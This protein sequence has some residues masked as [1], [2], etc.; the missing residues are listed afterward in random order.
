MSKELQKRHEVEEKYTWD[1]TAIYETEEAYEKDLAELRAD[2]TEFIE[3][4]EDNLDDAKIIVQ[5]LEGMETI[6]TK[7][8]R[9]SQYTSLPTTVDVTDNEAMQLSRKNNQVLAELSSELSFF[10]VELTTVS[11][12]VLDQVAHLEP[13][14]KAA[15]RQIKNNKKVSLSKEAEE[16]VSLLSPTLNA[17]VDTY[18][19]MK[20][21]DMDFLSFKVDGQTYPLSYQLYEDHYA[22]HPDTE[23]RRKAF[24]EFSKVLEEYQHSNASLY[25][26]EVQKDKTLA[27][28]RGFDSVFDHLLY[29]QEVGRELYDRQIDMIMSDMAPVMQKYAAHIKEEHGLDKMTYADLKIALDPEYSVKVS[30]EES[31]DYVEQATEILGKDYQD[32]VLRAYPERWIDFVRNQGK[33]TGGFCSTAYDVHPY[34]LMT[35]NNQLSD[36]FTLMHELGHAGQGILSAEKQSPL[37]ADP[38]MYVIEAP[39]T[40]NELLLTDYLQRQ[41]EDPRAERYAWSSMIANTYFHNFITHLHEAAFQ[42]EVYRLIDDGKSFGA[43][44]LS[45]IKR[46]V[47][48]GF[49]GDSVEINPGAELTW[50][51]QPHYYMGLYSYTYSAGLTI[52]TQAFLNIKSEGEPAVDKWLEFLALGDSL[53]P[54]ESA[55]VAGVD[56]T[57]EQPLGD[58]IEFLDQTVDRI[59]ELSSEVTSSL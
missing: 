50:M 30:I 56:I 23:V 7:M 34:I 15:T 39:S 59:I 41:S 43:E 18:E 51:R 45:A 38:S 1:L 40:F 19:T 42:R 33:Q 29:S 28:L 10:S 25:Y 52:A 55:A 47:L 44:E 22:F 21:A 16:V 14:F 6:I 24:D 46:D 9:T 20:L 4:Y 53:P 58:T 12:D 17:S 35:W 31:K 37:S 27:N 11:E 3:K 36:V 49:W 26:T 5:A 2:V 32:M 13:R 57:S 8:A 54:V 48:E